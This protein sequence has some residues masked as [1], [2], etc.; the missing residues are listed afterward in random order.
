MIGEVRKPAR[1]LDFS[2]A[3]INIVF[4]L[5]LFFLV[6]GSIVQVDEMEVAP[7]VTV[8]VPA[9]RL[10]RP[11][12]VLQPSGGLVLDGVPIDRDALFE[13]LGRDEEAERPAYPVINLLAERTMIARDVLSLADDI[14]A[15]RAILV[16]IVTIKQ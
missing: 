10:P 11:L 2:I 3:T 6:A 13:R 7:P 12:L 4:L 15:E 9:D 8:D 5:L 1:S 16:R 14:R